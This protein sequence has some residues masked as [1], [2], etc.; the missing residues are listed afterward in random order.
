MIKGLYD[1][2]KYWSDTGSI[3]LISD[4]HFNDPDCELMNINWPDADQIVNNVNNFVHNSDTLICLGD[5]GDL[6]YIKK[7]KAG[8]KVLVKGNHDDKGN[9]KYIRKIITESYNINDF[10]RDQLYNLV[11]EEYPNHKISISKYD[12][13][14]I[15][16]IDNQLFDEVFNGPLFISDRILLSHEPIN[17]LPFCLNIHGHVH[18]SENSYYIDDNNS[19]HLNIASDVVNWNVI[20]LDKLIKQGILSEISTIHRITIDNAIKNSIHDK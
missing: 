1:N 10:N 7:L 5:C 13:M 12:T 8:Y 17:G 4:P 9:S 3:Y 15:V 16:T 18:N 6:E 20:S 2:F 11:K 19:I 14:Y